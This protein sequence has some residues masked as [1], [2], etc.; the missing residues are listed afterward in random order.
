MNVTPK[1]LDVIHE[2]MFFPKRDLLISSDEQRCL[3]SIRDEATVPE[4]SKKVIAKLRKDGFLNR[5]IGL[6]K[7][8]KWS[9]SNKPPQKTDPS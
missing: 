2:R 4:N 6:T 7:F 8:G 9:I 5:K 3:L 1:Q